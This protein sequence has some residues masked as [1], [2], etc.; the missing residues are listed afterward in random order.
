MRLHTSIIK[1]FATSNSPSF[2]PYTYNHELYSLY[3]ADG[4]TGLVTEDSI[5][6]QWMG[7]V[8]QQLLQMF[9]YSQSPWTIRL[10]CSIGFVI[11]VI[12]A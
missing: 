1:K 6:C 11:V 5:E 3:K 10:K 8:G 9:L 2:L 7:K 4:S 12:T